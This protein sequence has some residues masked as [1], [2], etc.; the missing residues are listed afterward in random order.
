MVSGVPVLEWA[1]KRRAWR[2]S[3][4]RST[5]VSAAPHGAYRCRGLDRWIAIACF[6]ESD[7]AAFVRASGLQALALDPRFSTLAAR[8]AHQDE[9]DLMVEQ[10][11]ATHEAYACMALLQAAGVAAGVCQTAED[12]CEHDPQLAEQHWMTEVSAPRIGSWP[13]TE[14]PFRMSSTP[15]HMGGLP[16]R[17]APLYGEDNEYILGEL[18]GYSS[19]DIRAF[20]ADD[21]I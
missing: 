15:P 19:A 7:W 16:V 13:V 17:G 14:M 21:V 1:L 8:R 11:T 9:L 2:R 4:N 5:Y 3:G 20:A 10:W 18:L 12:R 6:D